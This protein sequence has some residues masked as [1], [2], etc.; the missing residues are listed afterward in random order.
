MRSIINIKSLNFYE[1]SQ[2]QT[3]NTEK[4]YNIIQRVIYFRNNFLIKK[5]KSNKKIVQLY[6]QFPMIILI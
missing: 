1:S 3:I 6:L 2:D 4:F 5:I